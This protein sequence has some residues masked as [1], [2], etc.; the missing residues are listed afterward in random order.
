MTM[1]YDRSLKRRGGVP[2]APSGLTLME[3]MKGIADEKSKHFTS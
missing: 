3:I 1:Q 2:F